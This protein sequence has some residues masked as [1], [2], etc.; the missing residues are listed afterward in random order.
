[1]SM[2]PSWK[3]AVAIGLLVA[4]SGA[5]AEPG[6]R[7]RK[8][9]DRS[10]APGEEMLA[11]VLDRDVYTA[12]RD[13]LPDVRIL[14]EAGAEVPYLLEQATRRLTE[15][16]RE[17]CAS[18]LVSFR[19]V[20]GKTLEAVVKLREKAP[21]AGGMTVVTPLTDYEHRV[22]VFGYRDDGYWSPLVTDGLI[23]DYSRYMDV[24]GRDIAL[25]ANE[26]RQF[27]L[28]VEQVLDPRE[29][30]FME[31]ARGLKGG[32]EEGRLEITRIQR[33]PFRI[34][35]IDLWRTVERENARQATK[36][37]YAALAS[38]VEEDAK[39][40]TTTID[41][42]SGRE[43]L[44]RFIL[45]T[46][47]RNFSRKVKVRVPVT[48]GI[49]T[50]WREIGHATISRF[51]FRGFHKEDLTIDFPE[52]RQARYQVV[53]ENADNPPLEITSVQ[54]EGNVYR[55]VFLAA[56]DQRYRLVYGSDTAEAP[57]Y[58]TAA[59]LASLGPGYE[60]KAVRPG[61][62]VETPGSQGRREIGLRDLINN[63]I[64]LTLAMILMILVLGWVL[65]RA[66]KQ[67][68]KLPIEEM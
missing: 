34:D 9:L 66:G 47:S 15:R 31:L 29:S 10:S 13:G 38:R 16:V 60:P 54:A 43:P 7:F 6:F 65:F 35:R 30:P 50:D 68:K 17:A 26:F 44:T 56:E 2:K 22:Q 67:I 24:R 63:P 64:V 1:M 5:G 18:D 52:Q 27:K 37:T 33:R 28:V 20:D 19:E 32:R 25:P 46:S 36:A 23:F 3:L 61:E 48:Q 8:D 42:T 55:L 53:I 45:E 11:V 39:E 41:V 4:S 51:Q 40:K 14:D 59:V 12:T 21:N 57:R 62:Q 58:D 49:R